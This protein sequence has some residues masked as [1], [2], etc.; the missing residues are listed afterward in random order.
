M[1][2]ITVI[3]NCLNGAICL[4]VTSRKLFSNL[5]YLKVFSR[6]KSVIFYFFFAKV[7]KSLLHLLSLIKYIKR[8]K[9]RVLL[10]MYILC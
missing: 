10:H 3:I 1:F 5:S 4:I 8:I 9:K 6:D 7:Y 2:P